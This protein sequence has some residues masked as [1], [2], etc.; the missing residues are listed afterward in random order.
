[1]SYATA[2]AALAQDIPCAGLTFA[3]NA[4]YF[5]VDIKTGVPKG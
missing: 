1:M 3:R 4:L 5:F 2:Y